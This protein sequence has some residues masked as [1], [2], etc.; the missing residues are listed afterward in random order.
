MSDLPPNG[1]TLNYRVGEVERDVKELAE[2]VDTSNR[3]MF[4]KIDRL[5]WAVVML[6][7]TIAGSA[8]TFA[9]TQGGPR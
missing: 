9:L 7:T 6:A 4:R 2:R 5:M 3:E 1:N 8:I